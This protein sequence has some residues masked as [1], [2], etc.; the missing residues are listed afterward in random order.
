MKDLTFAAEYAIDGDTL[1]G[2]VHVFGTRTLRDGMLHEFHP[3]AFGKAKPVAFYSHD[4]AKPLGKPSIK[5]ADGQ[6]TFS[7]TLGHQ[8]YANDLRENLASGLMDKMS[9]GVRPV[10]WTDSKMRN[11]Q[12]V[13]LHT[14]SDLFDISPVTLPAFEGTGAQLHSGDDRR[15]QAARARHRVMEAIKR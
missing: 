11:G 1:S 3:D 5:V 14:K 8:T 10:T 4:T 7:L 12:T 9:F 13:R 2:V 15:V 6:M